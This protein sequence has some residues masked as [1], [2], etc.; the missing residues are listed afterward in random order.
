MRNGNT[1]GSGRSRKALVVSTHRAGRDLSAQ[2]VMFYTMIA[3]HI[4]LGVS[5][6]RAWDLLLRNGPMTA[7]EFASLTGLT[8]GAVTGL[9]NRLEQAGAVRRRVDRKDRRKVIIEV[10]RSLRAGPNAAYFQS[11]KSGIQRVY[12]HYTD[13][14]LVRISEF[15]GD[16][17]RLLHR[18]TVRLRSKP[19]ALRARRR[20]PPKRAG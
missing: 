5:D 13:A 15:L 3:E 7:G 6:L 17:T 10:A 18:E 20:A 14:E 11:F 12:A 8:P 2:S 19:R 1:R 9:I 16:M 4:G